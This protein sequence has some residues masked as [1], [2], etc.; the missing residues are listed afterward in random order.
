MFISYLGAAEVAAWSVL[1]SIWETFEAATEGIGDAAEVRVAYHLGKAN[2]EMAYISAQKS[3][4][5]G[6][7]FS[8]FIT[9][10]FF[11]IGENL[12]GFFTTDEVLQYMVND[13]V[14]L[15]GLGNITM[16]YGMVCWAIIGAQGRYRLAT[17]TAFIASWFVTVP[18][19]ALSTY[20]FYFDLK[21][22][23]A[24][25]VI[26]YQVA[27]VCMT[28]IVLRSDWER[29]SKIVV[30]LNRVT[31]EVESS[32]S[33]GYSS[34]SSSSDDSDSDSDSDSD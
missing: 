33:E 34:S 16:T 31:G 19:A 26:G 32:D 20:V 7:L 8:C 11:I 25:V 9:S 29:L 21:G 3:I 14:P 13:A 4:L 18:M 28:Y 27:G 23:T 22:V 12:A 24:S 17:L 1:G 6:V 15:I 5:V 10:I 2:P 30:E